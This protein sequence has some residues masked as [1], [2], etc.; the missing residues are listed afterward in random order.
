[1][2]KAEQK[3]LKHA[4]EALA[5]ALM[6]FLEVGCETNSEAVRDLAAEEVWREICHARKMIA[7]LTEE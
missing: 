5:N 1:M 6:K 3:V 4:D 7:L 2:T